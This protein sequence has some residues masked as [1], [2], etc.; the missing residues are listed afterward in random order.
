MLIPL[1]MAEWC[2]PF[3]VT[4]TMTLTSDLISRFLFLEHIF[5]ITNNF[6]QMCL[7]IDHFL[8]G[9]SSSYC[10]ISTD[11]ILVGVVMCQ[12]AQIYN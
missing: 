12:I 10:D 5:F 1:G 9:H 2:I 7:M 3:W 6:L 11:K 8:W 4:L